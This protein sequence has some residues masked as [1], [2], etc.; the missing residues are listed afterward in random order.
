MTQK[1]QPQLPEAVQLLELLLGRKLDRWQERMLAEV[2]HRRVV[3][4]PP[5]TQKVET[6]AQVLAS[7]SQ[8]AAL[9]GTA[10]VVVVVDDQT[11][12]AELVEPVAILLQ[13]VD[14]GLA[15]QAAKLKAAQAGTRLS[16]RELLK[17]AQR[18]QRA[19]NRSRQTMATSTGRRT[20]P[21]ISQST[22]H[23]RRR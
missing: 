6:V 9:E 14:K 16:N 5:R 7:A 4:T 2:T 8:K 22:R 19:V 23:S 20:N 17:A 21:A 11:L 15:E 1:S 10:A 13:Q 18:K 3:E 12:T